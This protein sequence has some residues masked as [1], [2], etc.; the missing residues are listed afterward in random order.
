MRFATATLAVSAAV[1]AWAVDSA[2]AGTP[3]KAR[4]E[5]LEVTVR[6]DQYTAVDLGPTGPSLGDMDVYSGT[7]V[8]DGHA[9]G[10]GGGT[11]QVIQIEGDTQTS[12][13]L[14]TMEVARGS[15]TMQSL[16]TKGVGSLDM[17]ITGGTGEYSNAR[18]IA[19]FWDIATP[20]ER[21]RLEIRR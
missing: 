7:A 16:W 10:R 21:A 5:V 20:N 18:G 1:G 13:C 6:N 4:V 9:I 15:V 11:C 12:Q 3:E 14:I 17:A 8:K 19:R 2:N